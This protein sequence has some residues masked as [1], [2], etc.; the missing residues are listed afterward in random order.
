MERPIRRALVSTH[1]KQ[2]VVALCR[3][4]RDAGIDIL[5][6]GGTA[7]LLEREDV[8]VVRVADYKQAVGP[9]GR[10]RAQEP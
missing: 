6:S 9:V 1:D 7:A 10:D 3:R 2:G 4:L 8:A 5:S